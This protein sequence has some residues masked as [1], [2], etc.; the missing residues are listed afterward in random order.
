MS[1]VSAYAKDQWPGRVVE[2][3]PDVNL[4]ALFERM[5]AEELEKYARMALCRRVRGQRSRIQRRRRPDTWDAVA[6]VWL[7]P[8]LVILQPSLPPINA[9]DCKRES[10]GERQS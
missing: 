2:R 5:S 4:N 7:C 8:D 9:D 1:A 6:L 10:A 3:S